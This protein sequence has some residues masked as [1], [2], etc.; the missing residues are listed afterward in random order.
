MLRSVWR[1]ASQN[2]GP[3]GAHKSRNGLPSS[4][5]KHL[6]TLRRSV[7]Q[8]WSSIIAENPLLHQLLHLLTF[9]GESRTSL[10]SHRSSCCQH[11]VA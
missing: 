7:G 9:I 5:A 11:R 1:E 3:K 2:G 4:F 10:L 8:S 6:M